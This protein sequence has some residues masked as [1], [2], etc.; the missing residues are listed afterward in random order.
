MRFSAIL[1]LIGALAIS[2][3]AQRP[4]T[5][6]PDDE[7][8]EPVS[9]VPAAPKTFKARYEGGV[10]GYSKKQDG[11][12]TF[13]D[14][15]RR[16]L[17]RNKENKEVLFIPYEAVSAAYPDTQSRRPTAATVIGSVPAPYGLNIPAWFVKKK[18]RYLTL[19]FQDP[20]TNVSGL[21]SFKVENKEILASVLN[22]LADKSG[23]TRRG[24]GY[25]RKTASTRS[26]P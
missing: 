26:T 19:H 13:D 23:L 10:V 8:K 18:Y 3:F 1:L 9:N 25:I 20:D 4:R 22:S 2:G 16:L 14:E 21:T 5:I 11:T 24:E 6:E 12:L 7:K 17:F 15:N